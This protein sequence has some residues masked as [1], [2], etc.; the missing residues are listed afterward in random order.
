MKAP[1]VTVRPAVPPSGYRLHRS[2]DLRRGRAAV[3]TQAVFLLVVGVMVGVAAVADL[4]FATGWGT[5]MTW[6]VTLVAC[7]VYMVLHELTHGAAL[8]LLSDSGPSFAVRFPYLSTG[9]DA[10][11]S[12]STY[13]RVAL[14]PAVVWGLVLLV[15]ILLAPADWFLTLYV[16]TVLNL[17]GSAGDV[18][19]VRAVLGVPQDALVRDDGRRTTVWVT[20]A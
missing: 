5:A 18:V 7:G 10:Y 6:V 19:L 11:L 14:A 9:S 1:H 13:I 8:R 3:A 12:R 4:S 16:L 2:L 15:A 20:T 17:A